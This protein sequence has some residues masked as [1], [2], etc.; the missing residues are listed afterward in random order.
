MALA[1]WS[2]GWNT[3]VD[4][5]MG[6]QLD[7]LLYVFVWRGACAQSD[8][9]VS[10]FWMKYSGRYAYGRAA[11][12][13]ILCLIFSCYL[14]EIT[15]PLSHY[16][17]WRDEGRTHQRMVTCQPSIIHVISLAMVRVKWNIGTMLND[18]LTSIWTPCTTLL[19]ICPGSG[20]Y[21]LLCFWGMS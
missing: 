6:K 3:V 15:M 20:S 11:R 8:I 1:S 13:I 10:V 19:S 14:C 9:R 12:F 2:F 4:V 16:N 7:L 5:H 17:L 21:C 18:R